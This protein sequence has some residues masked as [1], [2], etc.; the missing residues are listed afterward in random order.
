MY[1]LGAA[2]SYLTLQAAALGLSTH[3]MAGFDHDGARKALEIPEDYS[4]GSVIALGYQGEPRALANEQLIERETAERSRKALDEFV[5]SAW[6][7]A[8]T[9]D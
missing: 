6:G 3:Q 7:E 2:A 5:F 9:L 4:L 8:A 1:D